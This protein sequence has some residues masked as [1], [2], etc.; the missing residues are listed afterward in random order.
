MKEECIV[1]R[2]PVFEEKF[3]PTPI[4]KCN[5]N[6]GENVF[7][8]KRDDLLPFSFGGNKVRK[9]QK[10]YQEIIEQEPDV[11]VTYGS[12]SSNHCRIIANMATALGITCQIISPKENSHETTNTKIVASLGAKVTYCELNRVKETIDE[13]MEEL[14]KTGKPY[15]IMGGGHGKPGTEGYVDA[16]GEILE[17]E[18]QSGIE[19][20]YIFH[21]SGTGATQAGLVV[22]QML[23]KREKQQIVGISIARPKESGGKVVMDSVHE[24][25]EFLTSQGTISKENEEV[26]KQKATKE[27]NFTDNYRLDGYGCYNDAI[28]K[29]IEK[30]ER[31]EGI[32]MD[33]TYVGKAFWGMTQFLQEN[34]IQGKKVLFVHTG[35]TP[36]YFNNR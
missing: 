32:A 31:L 19:F 25:L 17:Y 34:N 14:A 27:F 26:F 10:F 15:F 22:G 3:S 11:L 20:D 28:T 24:Y 5:G 7:Y 2:I 6:Y 18:K 23:A 30:V 9:A 12:S 33:T 13:T 16:Y 4:Y 29:T 21:A 35:G 1:D 8:I 36:L